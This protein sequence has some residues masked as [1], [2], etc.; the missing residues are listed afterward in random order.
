M[1]VETALVFEDF[2]N[3]DQMVGIEWKKSTHEV[4]GLVE[5]QEIEIWA[6]FERRNQIALR[7]CRYMTRQKVHR[8][9]F[10]SGQGE[11]DLQSLNYSGH[12]EES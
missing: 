3:V 1:F 8:M 12:L 4:I 2:P 6:M 11:M 9:I 10:G 7:N 5:T